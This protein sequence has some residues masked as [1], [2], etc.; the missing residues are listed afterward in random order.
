MSSSSFS[1]CR[2]ALIALTSCGVNTD[3]GEDEVIRPRGRLRR[4]RRARRGGR[5]RGLALERVR[6][7][8]GGLLRPEKGL[9]HARRLAPV[10]GAQVRLRRNW[11]GG[12]A[13]QFV[14]LERA[15]VDARRGGGGTSG[16]GIDA[17]RACVVLE[18]SDGTAVER[19][20]S[21]AGG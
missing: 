3:A 15:R 12:V 2:S 7:R 13:R 4:L 9:V 19:R 10:R 18:R 11:I 21:L 20:S 14:L 17:R 6:G 16:R 8:R 1:A 5:L